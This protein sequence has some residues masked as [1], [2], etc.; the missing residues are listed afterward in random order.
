MAH[1]VAEMRPVTQRRVLGRFARMATATRTAASTPLVSPVP[2]LHH[3]D[4]QSVGG[5]RRP[6]NA[7][8]AEIRKVR[9][10]IWRNATPMG[11]ETH[12]GFLR[13]VQWL[14]PV[15]FAPPDASRPW[16]TATSA[17]PRISPDAV[18]VPVV[19]IYRETHACCA[20]PA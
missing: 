5:A 4:I 15:S 13:L 7:Y 8:S 6:T 9:R 2:L 19:I 20:R 12:R 3:R 14:R 16:P 18:N 10:P 1:T 17:A 11:A